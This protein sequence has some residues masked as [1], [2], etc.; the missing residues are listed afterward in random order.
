MSHSHFRAFSLSLS[1]SNQCD[2]ER[3]DEEVNT[4]W[5]QADS[6]ENTESSG[7]QDLRDVRRVVLREG[8]REMETLL[9]LICQVNTRVKEAR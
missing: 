3:K 4:H 1:L 9:F 2:Y 8:G 7:S 5:T 6:E